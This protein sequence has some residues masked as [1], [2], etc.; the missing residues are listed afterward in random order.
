MTM[1]T[2]HKG[3]NLT[4]YIIARSIEHFREKYGRFPVEVHVQVTIVDVLLI[5]GMLVSIVAFYTI[6]NRL[7]VELKMQIYA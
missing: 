1:N 4:N 2:V 5:S 6:V 3:P 7:T